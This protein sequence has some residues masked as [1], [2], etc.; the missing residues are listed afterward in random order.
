MKD[1]LNLSCRFAVGRVF[2][3][4]HS[5][6]DCVLIY[7]PVRNG[8]MDDAAQ[9]GISGRPFR[10]AGRV[11][12]VNLREEE[13]VVEYTLLKEATDA[14]RDSYIEKGRPTDNNV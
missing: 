10:E 11:P 6:F 8:W 12:S 7:D 5:I 3:N 1:A 9:F 4:A 13:G 2:R 14:R